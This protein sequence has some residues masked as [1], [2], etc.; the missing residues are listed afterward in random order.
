MSVSERLSR[1][2]MLPVAPVL[3]VQGRRL[4]RVTP[5][6]PPAAQPWSGSLAG[7]RPVRLLVLG[8]STAAGVGVATQDDGLPGSLARELAARWSR[9]VEWTAVG[10]SGATSRDLVE[11]FL[12]MALAADYDLVFLS[13][14]A[15]DALA[16]RTRTAFAR[17]VRTILGALRERNP[18]ATLVMSSLPAFSRFELLPQ[19]LKRRLYAHSSSLESAARDVVTGLDNAFMSPKPPPYTEGFFATDQF[20]PSAIGY[21]D[22]ARFAVGD[23]F[24]RGQLR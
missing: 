10:E 21:R 19:P 14:G 6:L 16:I 22:W 2:A 7:D 11:R 9:G 15:N 24:A 8:D 12:P 3:A 4:R 1:V 23:A 20:H 17:D 13:I 18:E 5:L